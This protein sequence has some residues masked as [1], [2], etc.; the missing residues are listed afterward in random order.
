MNV[1]S[2]SLK[3]A[4]VLAYSSMEECCASNAEMRVRTFLSQQWMN[5]L[6]EKHPASNGKN[7][8]SSLSSSALVNEALTKLIN[9]S[10]TKLASRDGL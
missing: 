3:V 8:S 6:M 9:V 10:A 4:P 5:S 7:E 1:F 2:S